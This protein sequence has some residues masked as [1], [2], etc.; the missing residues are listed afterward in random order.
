MSWTPCACLSLLL[1]V[2]AQE[3]VTDEENKDEEGKKEKIRKKQK[4]EKEAGKKK[5][6][7]YACSQSELGCSQTRYTSNLKIGVTCRAFLGSEHGADGRLRAV[8]EGFHAPRRKRR[9]VTLRQ[10]W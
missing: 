3:A 9:R 5:I 1:S 8:V 6:T 7:G 4:E 2:E 10:R